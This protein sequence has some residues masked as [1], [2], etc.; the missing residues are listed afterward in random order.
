MRGATGG[1]WRVSDELE[2]FGGRAK[3]DRPA[4]RGGRTVDPSAPLAARMRP[5]TLDEFRGQDQL[6]GH[7]RPLRVMIEAGRPTS[8]ILWGPPGSGKTTLGR[9]IA[10]ASDAA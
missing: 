6:L 10:E 7:G 2:L 9:L 8:M 4:G 3:S 1:E 5:R